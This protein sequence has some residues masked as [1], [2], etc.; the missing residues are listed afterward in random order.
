MD[1]GVR[2]K[3]LQL[4][5]KSSNFSPC[6]APY[7]LW[8]PDGDCQRAQNDTALGFFSSLLD[9]LSVVGPCH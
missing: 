6:V 1:E 8:R 7:S 3:V 4:D 5:L 2:W 9:T